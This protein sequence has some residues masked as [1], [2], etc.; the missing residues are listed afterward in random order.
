MIWV[1]RETRQ[2]YTMETADNSLGFVQL[3]EGPKVSLG[4]RWKG[5][6]KK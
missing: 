4:C 2:G 5:S 1:R 6:Q 3:C